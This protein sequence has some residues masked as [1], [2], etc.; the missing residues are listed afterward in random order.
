MS[1]FLFL[2]SQRVQIWKTKY[3]KLGRYWPNCTRNR[4]ITNAYYE[5]MNYLVVWLTYIQEKYSRMS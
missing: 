2:F 1:Y 5:K 3:E 4:V